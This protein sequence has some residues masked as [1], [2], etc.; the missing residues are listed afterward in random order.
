M[1]LSLRGFAS[2]TDSDALANSTHHRDFAAT[3][4]QTLGCTSQFSYKSAVLE[5]SPTSKTRGMLVP[6][7]PYIFGRVDWIGFTVSQILISSN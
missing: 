4:D 7:M 3:R 1:S 6:Y 5:V 2:E